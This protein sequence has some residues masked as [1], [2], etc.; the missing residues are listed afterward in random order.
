MAQDFSHLYGIGK[1][2][3]Q[4]FDSSNILNTYQKQLYLAEKRRAEEDEALSQFVA[5]FDSDGAREADHPEIQNRYEGI[6]NLNKEYVNAKDKA[7]RLQLK[8]QI[9]K[10]MK[11]LE[12]GV[13]QSKTAKEVEKGLHQLTLNRN[14][15]LMPDF[16]PKFGALRQT[17]IFD[18]KYRQLAED[19]TFASPFE[20]D[21]D[22]LKAT[23]NILKSSTEKVDKAPYATSIKG[24]DG[25][26]IASQT[27]TKFNESIAKA[28][29]SQMLNNDGYVYGLN[30]TYNRDG[31]LTPEQVINAAWN[32]IATE[33]QRLNNLNTSISGRV[34]REPKKDDTDGIEIYQP[35][36]HKI[37]VGGRNSG[38]TMTF[39]RFVDT[40]L[41]NISLNATTG[42]DV[43][44]GS[45]KTMKATKN[46][47]IT[48]M[49]YM[50]VS[51][52]NEQK[53]Y[54]TYIAGNY[55][56][57]YI[58][59]LENVPLNIRSGKKFKQALQ[60]ITNGQSINPTPKP[61]KP[62]KNNDPLG[63]DL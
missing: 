48:G 58:I 56:K 33:G 51:G 22:L 17:S 14:N 20:P 10:Q 53:L 2:S 24:A 57:Q 44:A 47:T 42:Y 3:A 7:T 31:Q 32:D 29:F 5:D 36:E 54:V 34:D 45:K 28:K 62:T 50:P 27:G 12:S 1:G 9:A 30:K 39:T 26:Y 11:D 23:E 19:G 35:R 15:R 18:P 38:K 40:N 4:V 6:L 16:T 61:A 21:Y 60:S 63:L 41:G 46:G 49:G 13:N 25:T 55:D 43:D 59:P 8:S 37:R 52:S